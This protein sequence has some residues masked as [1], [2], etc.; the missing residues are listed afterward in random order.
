[1]RLLAETCKSLLRYR[2]MNGFH[3]AWVAKF[4]QKKAPRVGRGQEAG[5]VA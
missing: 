1:V 3:G 5:D 4:R 2:A